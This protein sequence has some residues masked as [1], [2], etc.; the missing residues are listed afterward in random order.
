MFQKNLQL[1]GDLVTYEMYNDEKGTFGVF[2][3]GSTLYI[4][5]SENEVVSYI[6]NEPIEFG[7]DNDDRICGILIK[8]INE[9]EK[10][11]LVEA[12]ALQ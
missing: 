4:K 12:L 5:L 9:R 1:I 8:E 3:G 6:K 11:I 7:L 10:S 2:L